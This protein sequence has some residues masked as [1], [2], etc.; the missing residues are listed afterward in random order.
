MKKIFLAASLIG[1]AFTSCKKSDDN[2]SGGSGGNNNT[3]I[4]GKWNWDT[5]VQQT[6]IH[7]TINGVSMDTTYTDTMQINDGSYIQFTSDGKVYSHIVGNSP[8][9]D[10]G[11]YTIQGS[12]LYMTKS[13]STDTT[14]AQITTLSGHALTLYST[15]QQGAMGMSA[16][17]NDWMYLSK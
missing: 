14:V 3:A 9:D 1:I 12:N 7:G 11:H 17:I 8:S 13:T 6:A 15:Y 2:S 10:T 16:Q 4:L 5:D